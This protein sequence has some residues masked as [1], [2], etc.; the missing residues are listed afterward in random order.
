MSSQLLKC[1]MVSLAEDGLD[2]SDKGM[3]GA[4]SDPVYEYARA[5]HI[6]NCGARILLGLVIDAA[7]IAERRNKLALEEARAEIAAIPPIVDRDSASAAVAYLEY[8]VEQTEQVRSL[9]SLETVA[10][11]ALRLVRIVA[12]GSP[13]SRFA[14]DVAEAFGNI[15]YIAVDR[16][17]TNRY[18]IEKRAVLG[19]LQ[20]CVDGAVRL[21]TGEQ[22]SISPTLE[23]FARD[24]GLQVPLQNTGEA[25]SVENYRARVLCDLCLHKIAPAIL[26]AAGAYDERILLEASKRGNPLSPAALEASEQIA[27]SA[28]HRLEENKQMA[29][30]DTLYAAA[31][32]AA[33]FRSVLDSR[34]RAVARNAALCVKYAISAGVD[35]FEVDE[36]ASDALALA[37]IG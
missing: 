21:E 7:L 32:A 28:A 37:M 20:E 22:T 15:A 29:A 6:A 8:A 31:A 34:Y 14:N 1:V 13:S 19:I 35:E 36:M 3:R 12:S 2:I 27:E 26:R 24:L 10:E 17:P 5:C 23:I 4:T 25:P 16:L 33:A 11:S 9:S 18:N 30:A